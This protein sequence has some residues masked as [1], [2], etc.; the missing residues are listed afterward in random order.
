MLLLGI[1]TSSGQFALLIGENNRVIYNSAEYEKDGNKELYFLLRD[2]L[3]T[4][5]K[6]VNDISHI[7]VDTGPGGTSRVRT[8]IA[9]A[10]SLAY[11]LHIP[12]CPVSTMELAGI[13]ASAGYGLPVVH[14]VKSVKG[15]AYIGFYGGG[16]EEAQIRYGRV[17]E[18]VPELVGSI[19]KFVVVGAHREQIMKLPVL[20]GKTVVDSG[21]QYGNVRIF[22]EKSELFIGRGLIFPKMVE[23]VTEQTI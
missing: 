6:K 12:V 22:I 3:T 1:S 23:S 17:E 15:N 19:R 16:R 13:D 7:I 14:S 8:G 11:S 2:A 9:F 18:I 5:N 10:N 21:M 20:S 4:C